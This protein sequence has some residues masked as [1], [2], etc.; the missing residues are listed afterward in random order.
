MKYSRLTKH[1][2]EGAKSARFF[3]RASRGKLNQYENYR[4]PDDWDLKFYRIFAVP[5]AE[6]SYGL[7]TFT[8]SG[9]RYID[10]LKH[11]AQ[12]ISDLPPEDDLKRKANSLSYAAI[13]TPISLGSTLFG[14]VCLENMI[15]NY[16]HLN[17]T[18]RIGQGTIGSVLLFGG[19]GILSHSLYKLY[20]SYNHDMK[21]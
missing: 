8:L 11:K 7:S 4:K 14:S 16:E 9:L 15:N 20:R 1:A 21:R 12:V 2:L 5:A 3:L 10:K 18:Q 17:G 6:F 19:V 13:T